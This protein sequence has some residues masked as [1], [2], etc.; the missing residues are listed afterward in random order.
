MWE[1]RERGDGGGGEGLRGGV[2]GQQG[3]IQ[4]KEQTVTAKAQ[5]PRW[6]WGCVCSIYL[7]IC[8]AFVSDLSSALS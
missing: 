5:N 6:D 7:V 3:G 1:G 2:N 4:I 8:T